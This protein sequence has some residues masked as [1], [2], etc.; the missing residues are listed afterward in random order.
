MPLLTHL[1]DSILGIPGFAGFFP[2]LRAFGMFPVVVNNNKKWGRRKKGGEPPRK[3]RN[4]LPG[5]LLPPRNPP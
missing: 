1:P 3:T 4:T 2:T 5:L